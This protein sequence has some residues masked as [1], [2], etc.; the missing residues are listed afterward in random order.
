M[1]VGHR[2]NGTAQILPLKPPA[3]A[4][5]EGGI[6]ERLREDVRLLGDLLGET[7]R[8]QEGSD[9]YTLVE[10][11]RA[12]AKQARAGDGEA[13]E[14]LRALLGSLSAGEA[15]PLARAFAHFLALTNIAEQHHRVRLRRLRRRAP[16]S[17]GAIAETFARFLQAG[18]PPERLGE[19]VGALQVELVLTAH[20]TQATRRTL[21]EKHRRIAATLARRDRPDLL[22]E[23]RTQTTAEL[24]R[25]IQAILADR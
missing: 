18:V 10:R 8:A 1:D 22:P 25:E 17:E 2:S 12:L 19:A 13:A 6:H 3:S 23:E 9:L 5:D 7:L 15:L 21:L 4:G 16:G 20:P 14:N 11:V 24:R